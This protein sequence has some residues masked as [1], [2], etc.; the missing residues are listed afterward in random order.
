[1][2]VRVI[3]VKAVITTLYGL[4]RWKEKD[5]YALGGTTRF[6][7]IRVTVMRCVGSRDWKRRIVMP[8][9]GNK[10]KRWWSAGWVH[11]GERGELLC[12]VWATKE[13][14]G[15]ALS[16]STR[17]KEENRYVLCKYQKNGNRDIL[18][19]LT[20]LKKGNR[21]A[22]CGQ[23]KNGNRDALCG[24]QK[25]GNRDAL[26]GLTRLKEGNSWCPV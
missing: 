8:C 15:K 14:D 5:R 1:M 24:Q 3:Q 26:C 23:Q 4:T 12:L 11:V 22:L 25:N 18:C 17:L 2:W 9:V 7:K 6:N 10:R 20:W 21:H 16:G 19:W 13:K